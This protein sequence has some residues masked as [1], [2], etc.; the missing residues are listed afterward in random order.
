VNHPSHTSMHTSTRS[1]V[2]P[3]VLFG[4][5]LSS[6][7]M[8]QQEGGRT[9][10]EQPSGSSNQTFA[11]QSSESDGRSI[12]LRIHNGRVVLAK[13]DGNPI[14]VDR[15]KKVADGY[16]LLAQDGSLIK[17][18]TV[19]QSQAP[20]LPSQ[21]FEGRE[22]NSGGGSSSS[23]SSSSSGTSSSRS[24]GRA[25][26][27]S[28]ASGDV[29]GNGRAEAGSSGGA[30]GEQDGRRSEAR[31]RARVEIGPDSR[32][33]EIREGETV[34]VQ[35]FP[36]GV[37]GMAEAPKS[38]IGAGLGSP[39][40]ALAHHLKIDRTKSTMITSLVD[41]LPAQAAGLEQY[42]VIVSVNGDRNASGENLRRVLRDVEPGS[43]IALEFVR[44]SE[45]RKIE[46]IAAAFDMEKLSTIEPIGVEGFALSPRGVR[47]GDE[48]EGGVMFFVGPDG[49]QREFRMPAMPAMPATP[50]GFDPAQIEDFERRMEAFNK[51]ME[52]WG[53]S[54]ENM[55][56]GM[57][58]RMR[59]QGDES[60][61]AGDGA[62]QERTRRLEE[63]MERLMRELERE[64]EERNR[65]RQRGTKPNEA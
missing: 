15:V 51:R 7:A 45:T 23:S 46:V 39:D 16:D 30:N 28:R 58:Q 48:G 3:A 63:Q 49:Q 35:G 34:E 19:S 18:V 42:D 5:S 60:S 21:V 22:R 20:S 29:R 59:E 27:E 54:M 37:S 11:Y 53:R 12:E 57:E 10:A 1:I 52:D 38:M 25:R 32:E 13:V 62:T 64:R 43:K 26:S 33:V 61:R 36:M 6:H 31:S 65:E 40:E 14:P 55:G 56:R 4:L 50:N 41:G 17:H 24:G 2:L 44:G 9:P 8:A 47:D